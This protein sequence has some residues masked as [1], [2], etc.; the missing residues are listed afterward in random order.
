VDR[1]TDAAVVVSMQTLVAK[2]IRRIQSSSKLNGEYSVVPNR[3][4][5]PAE[6][7]S[8]SGGRRDIK[9]V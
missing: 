6:V 2:D 3:E 5:T 1:T 7:G 8:F 4:C 9:A